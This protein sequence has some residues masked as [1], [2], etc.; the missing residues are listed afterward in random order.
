MAGTLAR[1]Y[2]TDEAGTTVKVRDPDCTG[3]NPAYLVTHNGHG[4]ALALWRI[5]GDGSL[6]LANSYTYS[7]WGAPAT[8]THNAY[9]DLG[10]RYLYVGAAGVAWDNALGLG[11]HHMGARHYSP[12]LGRFLQPDPSALETNLYG[13][14][15]N[16]PVAKV[17]PNGTCWWFLQGGLAGALASGGTTAIGGAVLFIGCGVVV[18]VGTAVAANGTRDLVRYC[19]RGGCV[20]APT[21]PVVVL[22]PRPRDDWKKEVGVAARTPGEYWVKPPNNRPPFRWPRAC[23]KTGVKRFACV[24]AIATLAKAVQS[25]NEAENAR[26]RRR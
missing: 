2:V 11:L 6:T 7:T 26:D 24:V 5:I 1:T 23:L 9:P 20:V 22:P 12:T 17:D 19:F 8:A 25:Y 18:L 4:D 21:R 15:A 10:F 14:G 13:Y 3:T 16:S